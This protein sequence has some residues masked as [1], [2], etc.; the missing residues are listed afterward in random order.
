MPAIVYNPVLDRSEGRALHLGFWRG[1][2][3]SLVEAQRA[4]DREVL[5]AAGLV[6]G[7]V[8]VDVGC[9]LG[10]TLWE[11]A[12]L[13]SDLELI[14]IN[15]DET[16]LGRVRGQSFPQPVRWLHADAC[17][18]P[19]PDAFCT[20]LLC[21]EAAF[22][23]SSR[24]KFLEEAARVLRPKGRLVLTDLVPSPALQVLKGTAAGRQ[25]ERR[26]QAGAGPWPDFWGEE[27]T[28]IMELEEIHQKDWSA[29]TLPSWRSF[30][31][32]EPDANVQVPGDPIADACHQLGALQAAGFLKVILRVLQRR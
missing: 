11:A 21:V 31:G 15:L 16:Q 7:A 28:E 17:A 6:P 27:A 4:L 29:A 22:H 10:S 26:V 25:I 3:L 30:L 13:V 1:D 24:R 5:A 18:L 32:R 19:L 8:V 20:H 23:F 2:G 9:G 12:T 14:G